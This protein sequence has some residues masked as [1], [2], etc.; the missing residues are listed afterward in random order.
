M[1]FRHRDFEFVVPDDWWT[2]AEMASFTPTRRSY[3]PGAA[4]WGLPVF[5]VAVDDVEPERRDLTHG[6]FND[7]SRVLRVLRGF[8]ADDAI[9]P[10]EVR[11]RTAGGPPT[12]ELFDGAH[13]FY[14]AVAAGF[15]HVPAV[16][17]PH[18]DLGG[19]PPDAV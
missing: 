6:V 15:S 4:P 2:A 13:R 14:C 17:I 9:P 7:E 19:D 1:R 8:R 10:V 18:F 11:R 3:R 16:D 12:F 5:E